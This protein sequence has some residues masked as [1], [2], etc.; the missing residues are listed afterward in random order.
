MRQQ[1]RIGIGFA[2]AVGVTAIVTVTAQQGQAPTRLPGTISVRGSGQT[3][4]GAYD[5][6]FKN[7]DG[8]FSLLVGYYNRNEKEDLDI[9]V[10]ANNRIEPGGPDRGQPTHFGPGRQY[11]IFTVT[12]PK[13][14][15]TQKLTWTLVSHGQTNAITMHIDPNWV[16]APFVDPGS[17][18]Q[19]PVL[20]FDPA[21]A[22]LIGPPQGLAASLMAKVGEPLPLTVWASDDGPKMAVTSGEPSPAAPAA[23]VPGRGGRTSANSE[24]FAPQQLSVTWTKYRGAGVVTFANARPQ[25]ARADGKAATIATFDA[26]GEYILRAQAN[27]STGDGGGGFECCWTN[28]HVKVTVVP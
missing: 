24:F 28:A 26:P 4:T 18:N 23:S 12:V 5:G 20:K 6:W 8:S 17:G 15:G 11:G 14:F 22:A 1:H 21:G 25:I 2:L 3:V 19:A 27:D 10:G 7:P 16:L 13:D 9:A